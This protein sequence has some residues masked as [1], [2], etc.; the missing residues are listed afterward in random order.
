[1]IGQVLAGQQTA[2]AVHGIKGN[3]EEQS[4]ARATVVGMLRYRQ[5]TIALKKVRLRTSI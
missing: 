5:V 4:G 3:G 2:L 1:M